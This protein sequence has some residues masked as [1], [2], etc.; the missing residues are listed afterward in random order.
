LKST[1]YAS[2][3]A[4]A[5]RKSL[6]TRAIFALN[7]A[8]RKLGRAMAARIAIT[9]TTT[10][11]SIRVNPPRRTSRPP[12]SDRRAGRSLQTRPLEDPPAPVRQDALIKPNGAFL[13]VESHVKR[14][15]AND[16]GCLGM[17]APVAL[18]CPR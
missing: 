16:P 2:K 17:R 10:R 11:S 15:I 6:R 13:S 3:P 4:A 9:A 7:W 18:A 1:A 14:D 12:L 8:S 5:A